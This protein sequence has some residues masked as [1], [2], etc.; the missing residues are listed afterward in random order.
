MSADQHED[1]EYAAP[2]LKW[3]D[4]KKLQSTT[5][6]DFDIDAITEKSS[7]D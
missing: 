7:D 1:D 3:S 4:G 5:N 6:E 2:Q